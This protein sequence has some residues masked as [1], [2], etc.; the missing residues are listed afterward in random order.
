MTGS[1]RGASMWGSKAVHGG[2]LPGGGGCQRAKGGR[3]VNTWLN[4]LGVMHSE[5]ALGGG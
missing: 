4:A 1:P 3:E 5:V 2:G